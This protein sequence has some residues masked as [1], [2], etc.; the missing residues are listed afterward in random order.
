MTLMYK[1]DHSGILDKIRN[2]NSCKPIQRISITRYEME[3][4]TDGGGGS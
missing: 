2:L 4:L 3:V 1:G